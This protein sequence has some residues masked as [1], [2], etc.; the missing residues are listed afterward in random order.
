MDEVLEIA[1]A[2]PLGVNKSAPSGAKPG[3]PSKPER[4][5]RERRKLPSRPGMA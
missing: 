5:T 4:T 2:R 1:L 3:T